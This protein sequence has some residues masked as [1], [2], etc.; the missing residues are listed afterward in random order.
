MEEA[1]QC[2]Y[3]IHSAIRHN[4]WIHKIFDS[5]TRI[6]QLLC[7]HFELSRNVSISSECNYTSL[8]IFL[9][10]THICCPSNLN[11][12]VSTGIAFKGYSLKRECRYA[13]IINLIIWVRS[14]VCEYI[15]ILLYI[16]CMCECSTTCVCVFVCVLSVLHAWVFKYL[17]GEKGE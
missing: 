10:M 1:T 13:Y 17:E 4:H 5:P 6:H 11:K 14:N 8:A 12:K 3:M 2:R 16:V 9:C 15:T 7:N